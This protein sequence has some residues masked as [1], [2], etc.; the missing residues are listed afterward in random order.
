M[1]LGCWGSN[2]VIA[3]CL[4]QLFPSWQVRDTRRSPREGP[5][6]LPSSLLAHC[7]SDLLWFYL[8]A[9]SRKL[10]GT[11]E[12][13]ERESHSALRRTGVDTPTPPPTSPC[14]FP[15]PSQVRFLQFVKLVIIFL[16]A[17]F[18]FFKC[19]VYLYS[20][21]KVVKKKA[22]KPNQTNPPEVCLLASGVT[23]NLSILAGCA[24]SLLR[25][26]LTQGG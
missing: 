16:G 14:T 7:P 15:Y 17:F 11:L 24:S 10:A 18:L 20:I 22:T 19:K 26:P 6:W 25:V 12:V 3:H 13:G 2:T 1:S 9:S 4:L 23:I 5:P 21:F 8:M